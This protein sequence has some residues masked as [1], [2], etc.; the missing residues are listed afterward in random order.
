MTPDEA[1]AHPKWVMGRKISVDSA[2]LMNKGLE[3]IEASWLFGIPADRIDIVI[4]PQSVIHSMVEFSDGSVLAQ[5]GTPDM[6]TPLAYAL[7]WPE[8]IKW[9]ATARLRDRRPVDV[10]SAPDRR[11]FRCL[12]YAY[13]SL[14]RGGAASVVLNAANEIAVQAFL[15]E[16]LRFTE[17]APTIEQM[18]ETYDPPPPNDIDD[19][20]T[21]DREARERARERVLEKVS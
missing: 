13:A 3:V 18:L 1:C 2:T 16:R 15:E 17:I 6:R 5:M 12:D 14:R 21:I 4:H 20:L 11:R 9:R 7:A 19:V 10:R 8:R